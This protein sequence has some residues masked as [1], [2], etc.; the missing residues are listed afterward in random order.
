MS[1]LIKQMKERIAQS[2]SSKK[3]ILYFTADSVKRVRFIDELDSGY[4]IQFHSDYE[5]KVYEPCKDPEDHEDCELC[6]EGISLLD[7]FAWSVWDYDT[8]SVKILLTKASGISPIPMLIE[9]Y[10]EFGTIKDRDYKIKKI[11]K[12]IGG[13]Y[14]VTPLDKT[15]FRN[16]KVK[17]YS[18]KQIID[19]INKSYGSNSKYDDTLD[20]DEDEIKNKKEKKIK[21][22]IEKTLKD[23]YLELD[24]EELKNICIELGMSKK[25]ITEYEDEE[26]IVEML[27]DEYEEIDLEDL[28]EDI[29]G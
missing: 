22:K 23:K 4:C 17:A 26:E 3:E 24:Y 5:T 11:G 12:G 13:S 1:D 16:N 21:K 8:N 10:N 27:F 14:S 9:S 15:R 29:E 18:K 2:G 6:K 7:N 20:D 19:I 28:L 25:E